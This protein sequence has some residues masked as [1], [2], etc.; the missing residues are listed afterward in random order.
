MIC[1]FCQHS[2]SKVIDTNKDAHG[3]IRRRRECLN[4]HQRF[5]TYE[6]PILTTPMLIKQNGTREEFD[7][8]KL[9][10]GLRIACA[11]R[12]VPA[13][14]LEKLVDDIEAELQKKGRVEVNSRVVGDLAI[15]GLK[16][17]DHV[18]YIRYAIV[19]LR[20]DDLHAVRDEIDR[21]LSEEETI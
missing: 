16:E 9:L 12:P 8:E 3:G 2:N 5:S 6:R 18:A 4:C 7:R 21:L 13:A 1:P 17:L 11:K 20:L 10:Q 15:R 19:Y 14:A